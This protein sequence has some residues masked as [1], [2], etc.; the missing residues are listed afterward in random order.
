[1]KKTITR[2]VVSR[3]KAKPRAKLE[4]VEI[5]TK[6]LVPYARNARL[7]SEL[8]INQI[9]SSITEYGFNNPVLVGPDHDIIA[10]HGRVLAGKQLG[11]GTIP[12]IM[13]GHLTEAQ[14]RGYILADNK[15]ALNSGWDENMLSLELSELGALG[16]DLALTGFELS[17]VN[18]FLADIPTTPRNTQTTEVDVDSFEM[19]CQCPKCGFEFTPKEV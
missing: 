17:E 8:Q 19:E 4:I 11:M 10:G 6:A 5:E 13:L 15:I 18:H 7:H 12:C 3:I 14:K 9:A 16:F 2:K 1:M